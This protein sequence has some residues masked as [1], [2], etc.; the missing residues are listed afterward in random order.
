[1]FVSRS[2]GERSRSKR[3]ESKGKAAG[4]RGSPSRASSDASVL[5]SSQ[6]SS[7]SDGE[8]SLASSSLPPLDRT[9]GAAGSSRAGARNSK[10]NPPPKK[11]HTAETLQVG[12]TVV[13]PF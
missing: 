8:L 7:C 11:P 12:L 10:A 4:R 3:S 6:G 2:N 1:M 5:G 13:P 9:A